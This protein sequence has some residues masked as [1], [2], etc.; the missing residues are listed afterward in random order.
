[1]I[2]AGDMVMIEGDDNHEI[3]KVHMAGSG[4]PMVGIFRNRDVSTL[5]M[6]DRAKLILVPKTDTE[7]ESPGFVPSKSI[8]D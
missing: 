2:D 6:I 5:Q 4:S 3:W 7:D 8:M 1:M